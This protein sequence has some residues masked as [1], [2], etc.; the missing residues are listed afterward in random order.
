MARRP[1]AGGAPRRAALAGPVVLSALHDR[2]ARSELVARDRARIAAY[3]MFLGLAVALLSAGLVPLR[4]LEVAQ[5]GLSEGDSAVADDLDRA[6]VLVRSG[7]T[8]ADALDRV[9]LACGVPE[10]TAALSLLAQVD[11]RGGAAALGLL[12]LQASACWALARAETRRRLEAVATRLLLPT[13][14]DLAAV[15][16]VAGIPALLAL[17]PPA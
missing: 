1:G 7:C 5:E 9:A 8:P 2:D 3:P 11:R 16:A 14:L 4:A 6:L 13:A 10:I 15:V 17:Q 12:R